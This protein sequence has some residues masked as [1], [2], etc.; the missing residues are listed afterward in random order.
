MKSKS[1][2]CTV[3]QDTDFP[4]ELILDLGLEIC[5]QVGWEV[6]DNLSW[7]DNGD[8]S[9]TLAKVPAKPTAMKPAKKPVKKPA[10]NPG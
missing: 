6:G 3:L 8:G 4:E 1:F 5:N 2:T 7:T 10:R 9:F